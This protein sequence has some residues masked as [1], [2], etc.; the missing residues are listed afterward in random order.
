[1]R[2]EVAK[3]GVRIT[4]VCPGVIRTG[5]HVQAKFKGRREA[6][7]KMFKLGAIAPTA[8]E[9][10]VA[11]KLIVD[12]MRYG[13]PFLAFP[14]A[15]GWAAVLYRLFP[16]VA[17]VVLGT[18]ARFMPAPTDESGDEAK[19]GLELEPEAGRL[20]FAAVADRAVPAHNED[21]SQS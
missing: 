8:V 9:A 7:Y 19:S 4:T 15:I 20:P 17:A 6:E 1:M 11:A 13:D 14:A 18:M 3:D 2:H 10:P 21:V 5:S 16:N 12:A